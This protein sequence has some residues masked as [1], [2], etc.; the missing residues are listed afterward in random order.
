MTLN[1]YDTFWSRVEK[2]PE[3]CWLWTGTIGT[4]GYGA[5]SYGGRVF[6]ATRFLVENILGNTL[7]D[8]IVC[9]HCDVPQCVNPDHLFIGTHKLNADDRDMKGRGLAGIKKTREHVRKIVE[10]SAATRNNWSEE[11]KLAWRL[12]HVGKQFGPESRL[13]M[14][15][16]RRGEKNWNAKLSSDDVLT[17]RRLG[18]SGVRVRELVN[19]Y[20]L[21]PCHV[22]KIL[23][24]KAWTHI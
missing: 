6:T 11:R 7:G 1:T 8:L 12:A 14:S 13:K 2:Q 15:L 16:K 9:H 21:T 17:I 19:M 24:R 22:R 10:A 4:G 5:F 3:G 20:G 23:R 18:E